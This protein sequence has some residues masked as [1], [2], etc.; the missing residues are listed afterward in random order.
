MWRLELKK[1]ADPLKNLDALNNPI[2]TLSIQ[3]TTID[4]VQATR[5]QSIPGNLAYLSINADPDPGARS[6]VDHNGQ[7]IVHQVIAQ[8]DRRRNVMSLSFETPDSRL[9][10]DA[11][12]PANPNP[13]ATHRGDNYWTVELEEAYEKG[14]SETDAYKALLRT[15]RDEKKRLNDLE[16][17]RDKY[18][19]VFTR[20]GMNYRRDQTFSAAKPPV[21]INYPIKPALADV[22]A[23]GTGNVYFVGTRLK[24]GSTIIEVVTSSGNVSNGSGPFADTNHSYEIFYENCFGNIRLLQKTPLFEGRDYSGTNIADGTTAANAKDVL[25][26][27]ID[28]FVLFWSEAKVKP[29]SD[30]TEGKF[31]WASKTSQM[32]LNPPKEGED[33]DLSATVRVVEE[34]TSFRIKVSG[35][36]TKPHSI[37]KGTLR[38]LAD[39]GFQ[40]WEAGRFYTIGTIVKSAEFAQFGENTYHEVTGGDGPSA[41]NGKALDDGSDT[42]YTYGPA[43]EKP[44]AMN[45]DDDEVGKIDWRQMRATICYEDDRF[46]ESV[47]PAYTNAVA[48]D[49]IRV[50]RIDL[51]KAYQLHWVEKDTVVDINEEGQLITSNGGFIRDDRQ[52]IENVARQAYAFY[53]RLRGVL[54]LSLAYRDE[55]SELV[56]GKMIKRIRGGSVDENVNDPNS[57]PNF[58]DNWV[59]VEGA[60][61]ELRVD[62]PYTESSSPAERVGPITMSLKT[63]FGEL[64]PRFFVR[65]A[66][67]R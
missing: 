54:S 14:A 39:A 36:D 53:S 26:K 59:T 34:D 2:L 45:I 46:C 29:G 43:I 48:S 15:D 56:L 42:G 13:T 5:T 17:S 40:E 10:N 38:P 28:M 58:V 24:E 47:F 52:L 7:S 4:P 9:A 30:K 6:Q 27:E 60:V 55:S 11:P 23:W 37:A 35:K 8:G 20:F 57:P 61:T 16:R 44:M 1:D 3:T 67:R 41:G 19:D 25:P 33:R 22:S 49:A 65:G 62:I 21:R 66:R 12:I 18:A 63:T 51:G 64:D 50:M 32:G 31:I